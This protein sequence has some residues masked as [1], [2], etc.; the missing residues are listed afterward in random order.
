[1]SALM[2]IYTIWLREFKTFRRERTRI[3]AHAR[4]SPCSTC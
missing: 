1:M 3:V 4:R 2:A